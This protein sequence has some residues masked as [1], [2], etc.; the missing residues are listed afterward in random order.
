M[1]HDGGVVRVGLLVLGALGVLAL[2]IFMIGEQNNLFRSKNHYRVRFSSATG[3]QS[4]NPVQLNG[5]VVGSV[6]DVVLPTDPQENRLIVHITVDRRYAGRVREDS[7][8]R[9]KTLGLL[10]DKYVELTSGSPEYEPVPDDGEVKA[11]PATDVDR[12]IASGGDVVENIVAIS[13]TLTTLLERIENGEGVLGELL[14]A[15]DAQERKVTDSLFAVLDGVERVTHSVEHGKGPIARLLHDEELASRL[16]SSIERL[17][18]LLVTAE[19]GDG[20]VPALLHDVETK[21]RFT[22]TL[23]NLEASSARLASLTQALEEGDGLLPRLL[24]DEAYGERVTSELQELLERLNRTAAA[25]TEG[26]GTI[27]QLIHDPQVYEAINDVIVG[28]N[29]SKLLRWLIRNR[30]KKGIEERY[31]EAQSELEGPGE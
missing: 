6:E 5:V 23:A 25:I 30:Q 4:G 24:N 1:R 11:A 13:H 15:R 26:D 31:E 27:S 7:R 19:S 21:E 14:S 17:E 20:L 2:G 16:T 9:I 22:R 29:E 12:L 3:L 8:A 18:A 10:G 28:I